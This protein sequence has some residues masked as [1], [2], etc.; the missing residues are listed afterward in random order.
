MTSACQSS[1]FVLLK[2]TRRKSCIIAEIVE[3]NWGWKFMW[4]KLLPRA[5]F[6]QWPRT[7]LHPG[8]S[9][10]FS[11]SL[12]SLTL[13]VK[14]IEK[15]D[16]PLKAKPKSLKFAGS[17]RLRCIIDR[18]MQFHLSANWSE[19]DEWHNHSMSVTTEK[20]LRESR[21]KTIEAVLAIAT[22]IP[23]LSRPAGFSYIIFTTLPRWII[24]WLRK[25][26][27]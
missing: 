24:K 22:Q 18:K 15:I 25:N 17:C 21:G 13:A 16:F 23:I 20:L 8:F 19:L 5:G 10:S 26:V 27:K 12:F 14:L 3:F 6:L 1:I 4:V 9:L 11:F 2:V 7:S